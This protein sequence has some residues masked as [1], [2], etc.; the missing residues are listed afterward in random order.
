MDSEI[1]ITEEQRNWLSSLSPVEILDVYCE[2]ILKTL[3]EEYVKAPIHINI[4]R[5]NIT[6]E[7]Q[8]LGISLVMTGVIAKLKV[9]G[10]YYSKI[11]NM[12]QMNELDY[13]LK[14]FL[15]NLEQQYINKYFSEKQYINT[16]KLIIE[17]ILD[18]VIENIK[19]FTFIGYEK[20]PHYDMMFLLHE[21]T[22]R[23]PV[24]QSIYNFQGE[25]IRRTVIGR[26]E[27][28]TINKYQD[29]R[30]NIE[31]I[32]NQ[33]LNGIRDFAYNIKNIVNI[34]F[35]QKEVQYRLSILNELYFNFEHF[36]SV[37]LKTFKMNDETIGKKRISKKQAYLARVFDEL[38]IKHH[39]DYS[40]ISKEIENRCVES[41]SKYL[42]LFQQ[43]KKQTINLIDIFLKIIDMRNS[44][45]SN[46]FANKDTNEFSIAKIHFNAVKKDEQFSSMAMHQLVALLVISSYT[47]EL[48]IEKLSSIDEIN[49]VK[50]PDIIIDEYVDNIHTLTCEE[51]IQ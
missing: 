15:N 18:E 49:G 3:E 33:L 32:E 2:G 17:Y 4:E 38:D 29:Y 40:I 41:S 30:L 6:K 7:H 31:N 46:G 36:L 14:L 21:F 39:I 24:H 34:I 11:N 37:L 47:M 12:P 16:R 25:D 27:I 35:V 1:Q 51:N 44:L 48:I 20:I 28:T 13:G 9:I 5:E 45:H 23:S 8:T 42:E 43:D 10:R 26:I 22:Y 19:K 50:V